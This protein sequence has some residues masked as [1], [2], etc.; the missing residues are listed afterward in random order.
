M[1]LDPTAALFL[2]IIVFVIMRIFLSQKSHSKE[3]NNSG[4]IQSELQFNLRFQ[5]KMLRRQS[6]REKR[7]A[8]KERSK[9]KQQM[10]KGEIDRARIHA[11]NSVRSDNHAKFLL[12]NSSRVSQMAMDVQSANVQSNV[13]NLLNKTSNEMNKHLSSMNLEGTSATMLKYEQLAGDAQKINYLW[14]QEKDIKQGSNALI[15]DLENEI[16]SE[17]AAQIEKLPTLQNA[18]YNSYLESRIT[19]KKIY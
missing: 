3:T 10:A 16:I 19:N 15:D 9:A 11:A 6:E 1:N 13:L 12:E 14:E 2:V 4:Q 8:N 18:K 7:T 17:S 5:E